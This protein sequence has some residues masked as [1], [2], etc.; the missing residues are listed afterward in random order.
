MFLLSTSQGRKEGS[1][2][3]LGERIWGFQEERLAE[4]VSEENRGLS[5]NCVLPSRGAAAGAAR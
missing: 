5:G 2:V 4:V 1:S 3:G